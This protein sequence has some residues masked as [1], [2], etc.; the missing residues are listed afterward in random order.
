MSNRSLSLG[1]ATDRAPRR[2]PTPRTRRVAVREPRNLPEGNAPEMEDRRESSRNPAVF[3]GLGRLEP[4]AAVAAGDEGGSAAGPPELHYRPHACQ[5]HRL[6]ATSRQDAVLSRVGRTICRTFPATMPEHA[7]IWWPNDRPNTTSPSAPVSPD[8]SPA[9]GRRA[10]APPLGSSAPA[11]GR[12]RAPAHRENASS[13][14][15]GP[16]CPTYSL[17]NSLV[18]LNIRAK[19]FPPDPDVGVVPP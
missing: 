14:G 16:G 4:E 2:R 13:S 3:M 7:G 17:P 6:G 15:S 1:A 19:A 12:G 11:H 18:W 5:T 10:F 8:T 9:G